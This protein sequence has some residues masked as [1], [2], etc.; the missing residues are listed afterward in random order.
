MIPLTL[1]SEK[2][3]ALTHNEMDENLRA[4]ARIPH[5]IHLVSTGP[6]APKTGTV[7]YS[8]PVPISIKSGYVTCDGT[9]SL[10]LR[11]NNALVGT[12]TSVVPV[13]VTCE[14]TPTDVLTV[15]IDSASG[16]ESATLHLTYENN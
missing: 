4:L 2:G 7:P 12:F 1:R 11:K 10:I 13:A 14:L 9:V 5:Y 8:H 6:L 3:S 16:G 15:D